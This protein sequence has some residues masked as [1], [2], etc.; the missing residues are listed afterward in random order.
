M[1]GK[2]I[3]DGKIKSLE[4]PVSD[5]F[6]EYKDGMA[7]ELTVGDLASMSSGMKWSEKYYNPINITSWKSNF[8]KYNG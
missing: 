5:F 3:M 4:Q 2:A 8:N 1:M 7:S 6:E